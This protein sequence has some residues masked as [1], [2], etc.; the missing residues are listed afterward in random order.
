MVAV[1]LGTLVFPLHPSLTAV[2]HRPSGC[3][4][5]TPHRCHSP[6]PSSLACT[7]PRVHPPRDSSSRQNS[8]MRCWRTT[9]VRRLIPKISRTSCRRAMVRLP[10]SRPQARFAADKADAALPLLR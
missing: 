6:C 3:I 8:Y 4:A 1:H 9:Y 2:A 7:P 5:S 10:P